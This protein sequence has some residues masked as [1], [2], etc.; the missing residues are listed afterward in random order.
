MTL[1]SRRHL[2]A[3]GTAAAGLA[4]VVRPALA[5]DQAALNKPPELGDMVLGNPDAKVT[6]IEY[7]SATCPHCAAFHANSWKE[8]K[9]QYID[10]NK[11]KFIFREFP[12]NDAALA[13]FMI[14][15]ALPKESYF[16]VI[17]IYFDTLSE[18]TK[19][20]WVEGLFNIAKQAGMT[21]EKFD[22]TL[23]DEKLARAILAI[24]E[25]GAK[26][27]VNGTPTFFINGDIYEGEDTLA[28]MKAKIDPLL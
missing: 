21:R 11:V 3:A 6:I 12:L 8:L 18:W 2:L 14:A 28:A 5:V 25:D 7:A 20:N 1:I 22:A 17:G 13:A 9:S 16:P 19:D 24:R 4:L 23:K 27:G 10:T 26:F 15:R